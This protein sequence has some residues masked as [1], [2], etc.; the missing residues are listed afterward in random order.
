[1]NTTT[2][3]DTAPAKP[4]WASE[5]TIRT[6]SVTDW[7]EVVAGP[8]E[9]GIISTWCDPTEHITEVV[10]RWNNDTEGQDREEFYVRVEHIP[11]LI[12]YLQKALYVHAS[13]P[14]NPPPDYIMS[15][16]LGQ[17]ISACEAA[18]LDGWDLAAPNLRD[19]GA[20]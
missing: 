5:R 6:E 18:G 15:L 17:F 14:D 12:H 3:A 20:E 4:N 11:S 9:G 16:T 1:M 10:A 7:R 8:I 19:G 13:T 2:A